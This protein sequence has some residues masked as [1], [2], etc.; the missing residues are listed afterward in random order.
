[1]RVLRISMLLASLI[2]TNG[3]RAIP[4]EGHQIMVSGPSP[5]AIEAARRVSAKGGNVVDAAVAVALTLSVTSPYYAALGGGG[6]ALVKMKDSVEAID[7]RETAPAVTGK[8]YFKDLPQY[9][10]ITGGHAVA[11]P[12]IP[13]G[14]WALHQ[15]YGKLKWTALF[16]QALELAVKGFPVSGEWVSRT[17]DEKGRF[18]DVGRAAL[19]HKN[20]V[21]YRPG[22]ILKQPEL[23]KALR[24]FKDKNIKGFYAGPVAAD[25]VKTVAAADGRMTLDDLKNYKVRWLAPLTVDFEGYKV[26]LMPPPSSGGVVI[27]TALALMEKLK[28]KDKAL[29]SV[30]ELHLLA[31]IEA[32]AFRGRS[33]LGDPD[34]HKNPVLSLTSSSYVDELAKSVNAKKSVAL[35]PLEEKSVHEKTETTHFSIMDSEGHAIAMTITLNGAYGSG[36]LTERYHIALNDEMDDF[37]TQ[38]G[39]ANM[40]GLVQGDANSV[41]AGKRPLSS[42]SPTLVEQNGKIVMSLG[43][44]GGPRIISGVLQVLYR[45]L[46]QKMDVDKAVQA[47]RIHHQFLPNKLYM[48]PQR[49]SPEVISALRERKH[50]VEETGGGK[51]YVVRLRADGILEGAFDSRGEGAAGGI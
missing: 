20:V 30:D 18:N 8:D 25:I 17:D 51:V 3:A 31:E 26:Y 23:A 11:V 10:S 22:E 28:L 35:A 47:P 9:S 1:M 41:Q 6:F 16:D 40:Y 27:A 2:F 14:L 49:F 32:R 13:A 24:E 21:S 50:V 46:A 43:S 5:W 33:L 36:L 45:T 19:F 39:T 7:F 44:P 15:K 42:M 37:T 48:E 29:L 12:G 38:P 34:F 4:T